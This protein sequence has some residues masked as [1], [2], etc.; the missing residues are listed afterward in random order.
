MLP[1]VGDLDLR[2][3]VEGTAS[4]CT[5]PDDG[6][7]PYRGQAPFHT[8]AKEPPLAQ[9]ERSPGGFGARR[10]QIIARKAAAA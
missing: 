2:A 3:E 7:G 10:G 4:G 9:I 6:S 1:T 8:E 5:N